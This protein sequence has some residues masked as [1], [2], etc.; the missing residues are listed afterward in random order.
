M[1]ITFHLLVS[2]FPPD[3]EKHVYF[4]N[5]KEIP[6]W[7]KFLIHHTSF[8]WFFLGFRNH[9][10]L[11]V[12]NTILSNPSADSE[13]VIL[14]GVTLTNISNHL[15]LDTKNGYFWKESHLPN[16]HFGYLLL[17]FGGVYLPIGNW[18]AKSPPEIST[19]PQK[20]VG[21]SSRCHHGFQWFLLLN[22]VGV[23]IYH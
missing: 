1:L 6:L 13:A 10:V 4:S 22:F 9:Q 5:L 14:G 16:H 12:V 11:F 17:V 23:F 20:E 15:L 18:R 7:V 8:L 3:S 21:S 19:G 2:N